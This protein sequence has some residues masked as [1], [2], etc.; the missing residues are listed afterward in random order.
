MLHHQAHPNLVQE[1][2]VEANWMIAHPVHRR[3]GLQWIR[4]LEDSRSTAHR[5][6]IE[7]PH[8]GEQSHAPQPPQQFVHVRLQDGVEIRDVQACFGKGAQPKQSYHWPYRLVPRLAEYHPP[9]RCFVLLDQMA[10]KRRSIVKQHQ[11]LRALHHE[12]QV[13]EFHSNHQAGATWMLHVETMLIP[14]HA[15]ECHS[16][17][18]QFE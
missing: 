18:L 9:S 8:W 1:E 11:C 13:C 15:R 10:L 6:C 17:C 2:P 14:N 4:S 3:D 7:K 12:N 5:W 16:H